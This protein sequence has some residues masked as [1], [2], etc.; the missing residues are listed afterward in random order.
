MTLPTTT[1]YQLTTTPL[2]QVPQNPW[3]GSQMGLKK[4]DHLMETRDNIT[5]WMWPPHRMPVT[6]RIITFLVG[7]PEL[8][9]HLPLLLWGGHTQIT[10]P[11]FNSSPLKNDDQKTTKSLWDGNFSGAMFHFRWVYIF[12]LGDVKKPSIFNWEKNVHPNHTYS[13]ELL[14][15]Q[16]LNKHIWS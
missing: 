5:P 3:P 7:N 13:K 6:T 12:F 1:N 11:K 9:L 10:P 14:M 15:H 16:N 8:N 2:T 4:L